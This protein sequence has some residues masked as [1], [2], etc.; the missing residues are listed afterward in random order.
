MTETTKITKTEEAPKT[1]KFSADSKPSNVLLGARDAKL[2]AR[3]AKAERKASPA[4]EEV[5]AVKAK[6]AVPEKKDKDGKVI[7]EAV[8]AVKAVKGVKAKPAVEARPASIAFQIIGSTPESLLEA[9]ARVAAINKD[10][11]PADG[12]ESSYKTHSQTKAPEFYF[13]VEIPKAD[14]KAIREAFKTRVKGKEGF[15]K[16]ALEAIAKEKAEKAAKAKAE[17]KAKAEEAKAKKDAEKKEAKSSKK[18]ESEAAEKAF[19]EA[20]KA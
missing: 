7:Q 16:P 1:V 9:A 12:T 5:K 18:E 6:A 8:P 20:V 13:E 10:W 15:N 19:D 2:W 14:D 17:K 4:V 11:A 3:A